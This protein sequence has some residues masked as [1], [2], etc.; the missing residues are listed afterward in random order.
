[1]NSSK[2]KNQNK[3]LRLLLILISLLVLIIGASFAWLNISLNGTKTNILKAGYLSLYL[4]ETE[5]E[6]I[7]IEKAI[8]TSDSKGLTQEGYNFKLV[9]KGKTAVNY[10]IY[11]S[12]IHI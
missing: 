11:L 10:T 6:G 4:D 5:T 1:M 7:N 9:N 2:I 12:L 3:Y 8:P